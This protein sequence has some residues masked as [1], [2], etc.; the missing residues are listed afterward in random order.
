MSNICRHLG[1][2]LALILGL[3]VAFSAGNARS[4]LALAQ[5]DPPACAPTRD[6]T[7]SPDTVRVGERVTVTLEVGGS[8]PPREQKVDVVLVID[9]SSSMTSDNKLQSAKDAAT[10]FVDSIDPQ[11][12]QVGI[13]AFD[14]VIEEV[15]YLTNDIAL[16]K[17]A[18]ADIQWDRG[19][20]LVDS[21]EAGRRMVTSAG[22]R[23]DA[24]PAILF[25][26]DGQHS[27]QNPGIGEIDR[28]IAQVRSDG[29][30]TYAVGLGRNAD[31]D[32]LKR[33]AG[34]D[35]RYFDSP[36][37]AQLADI[38]VTIAG[39]LEASVV[40]KS[41]TIDDVV[42]DNM[43]YVA[44]SSAPPA[45]WDAAGRTLSWTL[46]D[47][48]DTGATIQYQVEP[49]EAGRHPTN[50][51][52]RARY[53]DGFDE[54][55]EIVF[56]VPIVDVIPG[57][58]GGLCVCRITR[59]KA[60]QA[61]IDYAM[62][63]PD[64]VM[65]WNQLLDPNKPGSPPWPAPGYDAPPNP[66]RTCLDISNRAIHYHPLFNSVIWRAGCLEGPTSP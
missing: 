36:S 45:N 1:P 35:S 16:L 48:P 8:C 63:K 66:R 22:A 15:S 13:V 51:E 12:V 49:Q 14:D 31:E 37:P 17:Q 52:A 47:V 4:E 38:F 57:E 39:R 26:T 9:R 33:I 20:N 21:L 46:I 53:V 61:A 23:A 2:S 19:T 40:Y 5:G 7:A 24:T 59:L 54:P 58:P 44:G 50:V 28:V 10:A 55:G 25:M 64:R 42:P 34:D 41:I 27:V 6:K 3:L 62:A 30:V 43:R 18:I 65:G 11:L 29:I 60:P 32:V 56:P